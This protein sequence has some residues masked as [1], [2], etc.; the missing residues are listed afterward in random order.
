M[1]ALGA[2][3]AL[4]ASLHGGRSGSGDGDGDA[5][6]A[7]TAGGA[8]GAGADGSCR[9]AAAVLLRALR[10]LAGGSLLPMGLRAANAFPQPMGDCAHARG[11]GGGGEGAVLGAKAGAAEVRAVLRLLLRALPA[12]QDALADGAFAQLLAALA[13]VR[14]GRSPAAH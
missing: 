8:G 5:A 13:Q 12:V 10:L 6:T 9:S 3:A 7:A 11:Q 1:R 14:L 4:A 2:A